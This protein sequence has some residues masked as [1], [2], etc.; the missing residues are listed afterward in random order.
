V[1]TATI[2]KRASAE[3]ESRYHVQ[4]AALGAEAYVGSISEAIQTV[5]CIIEASGEPERGVK[6]KF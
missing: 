3:Q 1:Y 6:I 5:H 4:V 2:T